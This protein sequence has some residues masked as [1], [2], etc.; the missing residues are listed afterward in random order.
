M[1]YTDYAT[2]L[3]KASTS[4]GK[5]TNIELPEIK[6]GEVEITNHSSAGVREFISDKLVEVGDFTVDLLLDAATLAAIKTD[7]DDKSVDTYTIDFT[8]GSSIVDW[9]FSAFPVEIEEKEADAQSPSAKSAK[10][11]FTVTGTIPA[12]T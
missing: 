7:I 1:A 8:S 2:I 5:I 10:V 9:V 6:V 3:K 4:I 11:K 12:L